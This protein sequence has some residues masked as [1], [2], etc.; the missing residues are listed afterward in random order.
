[1]SLS[2]IGKYFPGKSKIHQMNPTTKFLCMVIFLIILFVNTN[3]LILLLLTLVTFVVTLLSKVSLSL[4]F[5]IING[6][7]VLIVFIF[8]INLI[9]GVPLADTL[10]AITK[11]VIGVV[12]TMIF[13]ITTN[14]NDINFV[15]GK[16]LNPLKKIKLPAEQ[17]VLAITLAF[18][19]IPVVFMQADKIMKSQASRGIDFKYSSIKG[20]VIALTSM[21]LPM[22]ILSF[23]RADEIADTME[24][25]LYNYDNRRLSYKESKKTSFDKYAMRLHLLML[26]IVIIK[27][28]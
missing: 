7:K 1:M 19:F 4:Y 8:V 12:Y 9:M 24:V 18:R 28:W 16:F 25:R 6:L 3:H 13:I 27:E 2:L 10:F 26:L 5:R 23:K 15:L 22:F 20:K 14:F 21:I 17:V 11:V